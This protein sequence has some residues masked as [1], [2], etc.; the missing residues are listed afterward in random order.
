MS[1]TSTDHDL[2]FVMKQFHAGVY[3]N[4]KKYPKNEMPENGVWSSKW[5]FFIIFL[6]LNSDWKSLSDSTCTWRLDMSLGIEWHMV[7]SNFLRINLKKRKN[8]WKSTL[9]NV[10]RTW[11]ACLD[12]APRSLIVRCVAWS[13]E[14]HAMQR[15][16]R[17]HHAS[18]AVVA[19]WSLRTF[20]REK[21]L[22]VYFFIF[23]QNGHKTSLF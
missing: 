9:S 12:C 6:Y 16:T 15:V 4:R 7:S 21:W 23:Q 10:F 1:P 18:H 14:A 19:G 5:H 8:P 17:C 13:P 2:T 20:S 11:H 3:E 22:L